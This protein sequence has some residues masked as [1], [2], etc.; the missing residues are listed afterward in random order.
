MTQDLNWTPFMTLFMKENKR[1]MRVARQTLLIPIVNSSLYLLI[2]GVSLGSSI[3]LGGVQHYLAFLIPGILMMACLNNAFQNSSSSI[4]TSRFHGDF[5]DLRIVPLTPVQIAMALSLGGVVRGMAVGVLIFL[6]GEVF[7]YF[8][9]G[10]LLGVAHPAA[11]LYFLFMGG[12]AFSNLGIICGFW[13]KNFDQMSAIGGFILLPLMYLGGVFFS[14]Q[15]LHPFWQTLS[16][17]NPMLYFINGVRFGI[18]GASDVDAS[19]CA[20]VSL[21][22][23]LLLYLLAFRNIKYGNYGRW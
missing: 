4:S 10:E 21:V 7:Y 16:R 12:L 14:L 6:V 3:N 17:F 1:F 2:F 11:L 23:T 18:L 22:T 13:A 19:T 5:E 15:M 20:I 9:L 8:T